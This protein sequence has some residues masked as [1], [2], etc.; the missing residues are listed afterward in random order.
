MSCPVCG[1]H[2]AREDL[3]FG[4]GMRFYCEPCGGFFRVSSTLI[5]VAEGKTFDSERARKR[6]KEQRE[7][8]GP[9]SLQDPEPTL[10]PDDADLLIDPDWTA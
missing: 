7:A 5:N 9:N 1:N 6:L 2:G 3:S 8:H 4:G 10:G